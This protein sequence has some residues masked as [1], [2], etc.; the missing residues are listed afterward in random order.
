[1]TEIK[2]GSEF[3]R[4]AGEQVSNTEEEQQAPK[5]N[6]KIHFCSSSAQRNP[7]SV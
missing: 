5:N 6:N 4:G 2:Y 7:T 1:M 3:G